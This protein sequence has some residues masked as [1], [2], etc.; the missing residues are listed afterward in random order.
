MIS[1]RAILSLLFTY[2]LLTPV[3]SAGDI[4]PEADLALEELEAWEAF[5]REVETPDAATAREEVPSLPQ[6]LLIRDESLRLFFLG[7]HTNNSLLSE[8][9]VPA[10][11]FG[12]GA[13]AF[14]WQTDG[15][16]FFTLWALAERRRFTSPE[17]DLEDEWTAAAHIRYEHGL[18]LGG[19]TLEGGIA[20]TRQ[21]YDAAD[22]ALPGEATVDF[23]GVVLPR[24]GLSW[25]RLFGTGQE[26][27]VGLTS[28]HALYQEIDYNNQQHG[29]RMQVRTPLPRATSATLGWAVRD[30]IFDDEPPRSSIGLP[31]SANRLR[32]VR[33]DADLLLR[34]ERTWWAEHSWQLRLFGSWIPA[35]NSPWHGFERRGME[36]RGRST[37]SPWRL[38][39]R[40]SW[41]DVAYRARRAAPGTT[42]PL[43][44]SRHTG[45]LA[46]ERSLG[47]WQLRGELEYNR[48]SSNDPASNY[49]AR[50][51]TT[52]LA[53]DF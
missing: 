11:F 38:H 43:E 10:A 25:K 46:L 4:P 42:T 15:L 19:W 24:A 48:F 34:H 28:E 21:V 5:L 6:A 14:V 31:L 36:F 30:V 51:L 49:R 35:N 40:W 2:L 3:L 52:T 13:E 27:E 7:G 53:K 26:L 33:Y 17:E 22:T 1:I 23:L 18:P 39:Y 44:Q 45:A 41:S 29:F 8:R 9:R 12:G 16:H 32:Y 50:Q 37:L 20:A 47:S